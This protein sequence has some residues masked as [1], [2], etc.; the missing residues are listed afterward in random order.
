MIVGA[1]CVDS[2]TSSVAN[3]IL[4]MLAIGASM[5]WWLA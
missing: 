4:G 5:I 1:N 3:V 2:G